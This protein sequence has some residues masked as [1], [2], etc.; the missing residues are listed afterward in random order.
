MVFSRSLLWLGVFLFRWEIGL[1]RHVVITLM[2][3]IL[4]LAWLGM[5]KAWKLGSLEAWEPESLVMA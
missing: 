2:H 3:Q 4:Y 5:V 1:A